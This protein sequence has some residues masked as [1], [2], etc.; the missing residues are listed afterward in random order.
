M[1]LLGRLVFALRGVVACGAQAET[2]LKVNT[3]AISI[4]RMFKLVMVSSV[5]KW[6]ISVQMS[7][8]DE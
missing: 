5:G 1:V 3:V 7:A 2:A 4:V 8:F 6:D